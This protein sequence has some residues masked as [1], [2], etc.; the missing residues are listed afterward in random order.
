MENSLID[1]H[2]ICYELGH[3]KEGFLVICMVPNSMLEEFL[4][5]VNPQLSLIGKEYKVVNCVKIG[6]DLYE[7]ETN[8]PYLMYLEKTFGVKVYLDSSVR[9][10]YCQIYPNDFQRENI[11]V[12]LTFNDVWNG[13]IQ[14]KEIYN[15]ISDSDVDSEVRVRI[16]QILSVLKGCEYRET[17]NLWRNKGVI[18]LW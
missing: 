12:G 11:R 16:F 15:V 6:K 1:N 18:T 10:V 8:L 5:D 14:G 7:L 3:N 4:Q 2:L 13:L 9:D 17:Y